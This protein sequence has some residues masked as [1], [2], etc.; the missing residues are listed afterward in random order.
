[1]ATSLFQ[2]LNISRHDLLNRMLDLDTVSSNLANV[3]TPGFRSTRLNFQELFAEEILGGS[4]TNGSQLI[5]TPGNLTVSDNP[6][7]WCIRG[8][9]FF[10]VKLPNGETGYTRDGVFSLDEKNQ[11]VTSSGY[12]LD[13]SGNIP[14]TAQSLTIN[15]DG[16]VIVTLEDGTTDEAGTVELARFANSSALISGGDNVWLPSDASG[17]AQMGHPGMD[18]TGTIQNY[19]YEMSNVDLTEEMTRLIQIQR[20]FQMSAR[21]LSQ[22]DTMIG[23][24]IHMRKA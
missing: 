21:L 23:Q 16:L 8:D 1:M 18:G 20:A 14:E 3:N 5:T 7:D 10:P 24:A 4:K 17:E 12:L 15:P 6:L 2:T 9:G 13:W 22:T 11:L 19:A